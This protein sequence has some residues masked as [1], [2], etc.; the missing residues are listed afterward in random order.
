MTRLLH[1]VA[2]SWL[3]LA[4]IP[5][6][7]AAPAEPVCENGVCTFR[8]TAEQL[9][10]KAD[11][12]VSQHAFADAA[13]LIAA[14]ENAPQYAMERRFLAGYSAIET[15]DIDT[16]IAQFRAI[17]NNH[18]EQTRVRLELARALMIK[19]KTGGA[20]YHYR[21]AQEDQSLPPDIVATIRTT[22]GILRDQRQ[23]NFNVDFG[24]A[25]DSNITNGTNA[26][27]VDVAFGNQTVALRLD[28]AARAQ[29]GTGQIA[30]VSGSVRLKLAKGTALVIDGD[31]QFVNYAGTAFDDFAVQ[32]AA[33]PE[34]RLS[35]TTTLAVQA[36]VA[37][38]W[39]G[40]KA[41]NTTGGIKG[42]V[43][44]SLSTRDRIGMSFD[45]RRTESAV[46]G[47]YSGWQIGAYG[48]YERVIARSMIASA[49]LFARR[50]A[51]NAAA[52]A[53]YEFGTNIGI[54]GELPLGI[55]AGV[56]GGISRARNDG[57]L[58]LFSSQPRSDWRYN[59]RVNMGLRSIR[60]LGFSPSV[61]YTYA[62]N[63]SSL[64]LYDTHRHRFRFALARYF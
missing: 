62:E 21:L 40:G 52:F 23:W 39:F 54:G 3:A 16:A 24:V 41:A 51:L 56:S 43:Q 32:A 28:P 17:L 6:M 35:D 18:P 38:R 58:S 64:S 60:V 7:A 44:H 11:L 49:S 5:A 8:L 9:L 45:A 10:A 2:A 22:R 47:F 48:T 55:T 46:S 14:L 20:D 53:G 13:P 26:E 25:P 61:T 4:S 1:I 15:G 27:S 57:P 37:Q 12:L 30:G 59:A 36:V 63:A 50:D 31:S 29:S 42:A 33:G 19:G 34:F